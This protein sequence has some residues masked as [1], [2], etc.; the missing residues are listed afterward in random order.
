MRQATRRAS[1]Y[2]SAPAWRSRIPRLYQKDERVSFDDFVRAGL[3]VAA[4]PQGPRGMR[5]GDRVA[6]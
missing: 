5:K 3:A 2:A 4:M 6:W 1:L